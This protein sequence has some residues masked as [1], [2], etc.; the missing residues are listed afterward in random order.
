[1]ASILLHLVAATLYGTLAVISWRSRQRDSSLSRPA[2]GLNPWQHAGLLAALLAHGLALGGELF[3]G[4]TMYF[5]FSI[6]VSTILWLAIAFYW[7]ESFYAQMEGLQML[8]LPVA[9]VA[10][11]LPLVFPGEHVLANVGSGQFRAHFLIAM[12]AYSLFTLAAVHAALMAIVERSLHRGRLTPL[13]AGLPPLLTMET[14]L[15]QLIHIAFVLLTLTLATGMLFSESL[16][17]KAVTF[18][19]KTDF[20]IAS[21][22]I[23]AILLAGRHFAGWR[24]RTALRWTLSGFGVLVLAYVGYRFV[25]EIILG[26]SA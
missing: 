12:L 15:F 1:M 20:A 18:N 24:G 13:L 3:A 14:L 16:F 21:W 23:F 2:G 25:L 4:P 26:R 9:A 19:H 10:V 22:V 5:G 11:L 8:V 17:G 6:A 7:I